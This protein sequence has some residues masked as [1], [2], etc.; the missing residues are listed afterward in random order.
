M[1]AFGCDTAEIVPHSDD[2]LFDLGVG[3]VG[4]GAA[5]IDPRPFG[6]SEKGA[7]TPRQRAA[8]GGSPIERQRSEHTDQSRG[9]PSLQAMGKAGR[10]NGGVGLGRVH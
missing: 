7:E 1:R 3:Q 8:K 6:N 10:L 4:I 2:D 9:A 5:Q